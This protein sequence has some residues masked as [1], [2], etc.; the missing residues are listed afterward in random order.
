MA[1]NVWSPVSV[2]A[3]LERY[4][5]TDRTTASANL[6]HRIRTGEPFTTQQL[7]DEE[8]C[9][10]ANVSLMV[11]SMKVVG[12]KITRTRVGSTNAYTYRVTKPPPDY[13][14]VEQAQTA[15]RV[16]VVAAAEVLPTEPPAPYPAL[17]ATLGV[18]AL[19]LDDAGQLVMQ[20]SDGNG[21]SWRV[22]VT[23]HVV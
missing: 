13:A 18:R 22:Q 11:R 8:R 23:G 7:A 3:R 1:R 6:Y 4:E 2:A 12:W 21:R 16:A 9:S 14:A 10:S 17:G 5:T 20:L 15:R 19:A